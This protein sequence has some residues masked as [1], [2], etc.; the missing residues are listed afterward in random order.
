MGKRI[1]KAQPF[2]EYVACYDLTNN[3]HSHAGL[4]WLDVSE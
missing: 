3:A 4:S 2:N 1:W